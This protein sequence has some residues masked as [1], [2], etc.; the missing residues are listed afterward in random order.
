[1]RQNFY[2]CIYLLSSVCRPSF[3][4]LFDLQVDINFKIIFHYKVSK[5][6]VD[7]TFAQN[8]AQ[9][10]NLTSKIMMTG[11]CLFRIV[12]RRRKLQHHLDVVTMW[13][14]S[15]L[16]TDFLHT[17]KL[18]KY[19]LFSCSTKFGNFA[20]ILR[21]FCAIFASILLCIGTKI[22]NSLKELF[23]SLCC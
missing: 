2:Q 10:L 18:W 19:K 7:A 17:A 22:F 20:R 16:S 9:S 23:C 8:L 13:R 11:R 3:L 21:D 5:F 1:M 14:S 4:R 6:H 15:K 12:I